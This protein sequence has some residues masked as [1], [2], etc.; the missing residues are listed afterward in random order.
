LL[1]ALYGCLKTVQNVTLA[2]LLN[3]H[4]AD[5][6]SFGNPTVYPRR[7]VR[8]GIRFQKHVSP[9]ALLGRQSLPAQQ[10]RQLLPFLVA[11]PDDITLGHGRLSIL[12]A[13][14]H[15]CAFDEEIG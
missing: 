4:D 3:R 8:A 11:Q 13:L 14:A 5:I 15:P 2:N 9:H 1:L 6:K 10:L 12:G 7:A